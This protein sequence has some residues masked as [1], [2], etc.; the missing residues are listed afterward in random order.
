MMPFVKN[1]SDAKVQPFINSRRVQHYFR[2]KGGYSPTCNCGI[3]DCFGEYSTAIYGYE[4]IIQTDLYYCKDHYSNVKYIYTKMPNKKIPIISIKKDG[5][6]NTC[7]YYKCREN[8][9]IKHEK[10]YAVSSY[11]KT[12]MC[13]NCK[14]EDE[15]YAHEGAISFHPDEPCQTFICPKCLIEYNIVFDKNQRNKQAILVNCDNLFKPVGTVSNLN[16]EFLCRPIY[17]P[18]AKK[19]KN[20]KNKE[21]NTIPENVV[22]TI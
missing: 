2:D 10:T 6:D 5:D 12:I 18:N 3:C 22:T 21:D 4:C 20:R 11:D 13:K 8:V 19:N 17:R 14:P 16:S 15:S 1:T 7:C 9:E